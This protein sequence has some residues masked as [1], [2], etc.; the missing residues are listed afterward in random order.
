[1]V[2]FHLSF[3]VVFFIVLVMQCKFTLSNYHKNSLTALMFQVSA[4]ITEPSENK[5]VMREELP[6]KTSALQK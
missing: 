1:M 2:L 3:I 6:D 4:A 5:G